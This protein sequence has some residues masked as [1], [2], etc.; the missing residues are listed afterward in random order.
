MKSLTLIITLLITGVAYGQ[1]DAKAQALIQE[2]EQAAGGWDNL[3]G[4]RD[5]SYTYD[6]DYPGTGQKD[7][8]TER[9]IFEGEHSW[10]KYTQH[11]INV[12]P[13]EAGTVTQ[14]YV[15]GQPAISHN[16]KLMQQPELLGG[17]TFLRKANYFWFTMFFKL[18]NPG[19]IATLRDREKMNGTNYNVVHITYDPAVTGKEANDEYILYIN[20]KTK[21]VDQF[22]FSLPAMGVGA[23]VILMEVDYETINGLAIPTKRR[24]FQPGA[25]GQLPPQPQLVQTLTNIKFNNGFS[26]EDFMLK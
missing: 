25:D 9:Y 3:W 11:D 21:L 7:L 20:P 23:P 8:S 15:N 6:Y 24:I 22:Y 16:G 10:A 1:S 2:M 14:T 13:G 19:V 26:P 4:Q 17:T 5:V 12:M 18:D